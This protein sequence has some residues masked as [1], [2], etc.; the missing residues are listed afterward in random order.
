MK[1]P[2]AKHLPVSLTCLMDMYILYMVKCTM[3]MTFFMMFYH[4]SL[5]CTDVQTI[6]LRTMYASLPQVAWG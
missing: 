2:R 6:N 3:Y 4:H 5:V 1:L